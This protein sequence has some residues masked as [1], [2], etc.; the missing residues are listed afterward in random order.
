MA[1]AM[2]IF[3]YFMRTDPN[4]TILEEN[5]FNKNLNLKIQKEEEAQNQ[6]SDPRNMIR[7]TLVETIVKYQKMIDMLCG[8]FCFMDCDT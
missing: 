3:D 7:E 6:Q 4:L 1:E 2:E 8:L 5:E